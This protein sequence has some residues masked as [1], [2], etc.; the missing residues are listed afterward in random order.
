MMREG[1]TSS[2]GGET[3]PD[4]DLTGGIRLVAGDT[5]RGAAKELMLGPRTDIGTNITT[6]RGRLGGATPSIRKGGSRRPEDEATGLTTDVE[7][8]PV[9]L[10]G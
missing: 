2:Q 5:T 1:P 10:A 3:G 7:V 4:G 6:R 8:G 9:E